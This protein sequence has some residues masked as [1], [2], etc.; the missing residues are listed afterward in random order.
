MND[1][2]KMYIIQRM[3]KRVNREWKRILLW[4]IHDEIR[5]ISI[6][7]RWW[8]IWGWSGGFRIEANSRELCKFKLWNIFSSFNFYPFSLIFFLFQKFGFI[9]VLKVALNFNL[10]ISLSSIHSLKEEKSWKS[11]SLKV[12]KSKQTTT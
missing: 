7:L 4:D 3:N 12:P 2:I 9:F 6:F 8:H 10:F 1:P 5:S 11:E